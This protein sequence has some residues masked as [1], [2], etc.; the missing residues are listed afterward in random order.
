MRRIE[1]IANRSV[2]TELLEVIERDTPGL[3]YTLIPDVQGRG[4]QGV[5]LGDAVWPELNVYILIVCEDEAA[6]LVE[7]AVR[8]LKT[9]FPREGIKLLSSEFQH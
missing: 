4:R 2:S 6:G 3:P 9:A 1:I 7:K 5:R 8:E